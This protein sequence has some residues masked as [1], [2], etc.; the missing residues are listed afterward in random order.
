MPALLRLIVLT[1]AILLLSACQSIPKH[2]VH[3]T[4]L[5]NTHQSGGE[6]IVLPLD[7][8]V[9]EFSA[10]GLTE[11][12]PAWTREANEN[13]R[14]EL[15]QHS[16][17]VAPEL[18]LR[19]LPD[20]PEQEM[21]QVKEHIALADLTMGNAL[22]LSG[23]TGG[24]AWRHKFKHFDYTLGPGLAFLADRTGA[25]KALLLFGQDIKSS[26]GRKL[27]FLLAAAA[28][29][30]IPLGHC[31]AVAAIV[32]LRSGDLLWMHQYVSVSD[33]TFLNQDDTREIVTELFKPYPGI[34]E[35]RKFAEAK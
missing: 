8:K 23:P 30:Q 12:V 14:R 11:E 9:K 2:K 27:T 31:V 25:D 21:A 34:E 15:Q 24:Q 29:V 4:L 32:D 19:F 6:V 17:K 7:L 10:G 22:A 1:I 35:Y 26:E 18:K 20:L 16:D 5:D 3:Y 13:F 33:S 28:G